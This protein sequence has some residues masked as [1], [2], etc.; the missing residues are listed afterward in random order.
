MR[1]QCLLGRSAIERQHSAGLLVIPPRTGLMGP[2]R[3]DVGQ[4]DQRAAGEIG[5]QE[6]HRRRAEQT[7]E[8]TSDGLDRLHGASVLGSVE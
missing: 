3:S 5:D 1:A 7:A 4:S 2:L 8:L 6:G